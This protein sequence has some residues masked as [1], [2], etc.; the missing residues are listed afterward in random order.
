ML[1]LILF[2]FQGYFKG[3]TSTFLSMYEIE[4]IENISIWLWTRSGKLKHVELR[5]ILLREYAKCTL[6]FVVNY[7]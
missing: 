4:N 6:L 3:Q 1:L 7:I 2:H 5:S